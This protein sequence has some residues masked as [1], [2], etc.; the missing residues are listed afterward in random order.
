MAFI[1]P[2]TPSWPDFVK[3]GIANP[4]TNI[5]KT[6]KR[7]SIEFLVN[8]FGLLNSWLFLNDFTKTWLVLLNDVLHYDLLRG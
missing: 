5:K 4:V 7:W 6:K 3:M 8:T 2:Y 1:C